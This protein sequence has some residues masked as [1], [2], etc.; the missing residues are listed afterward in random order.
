VNPNGDFDTDGYITIEFINKK[1]LTRNQ[2]ERYQIHVSRAGMVRVDFNE[3]L[4]ESV[5]KNG[6]GIDQR[7]MGYSSSSGGGG[8]AD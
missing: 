2:D 1:A 7:S 3:S 5:A 8:S 6:L 4:Y